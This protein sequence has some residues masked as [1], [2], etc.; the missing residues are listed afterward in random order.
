MPIQQIA[1]ERFSLISPGSFEQVVAALDAVL[2]HPEMHE[3]GASMAATES[4]QQLEHV[5]HAATGRSGFLEFARFD[6]GQVLSKEQGA[7]APK[8]L[9]IVL[10]N[11]LVMKQ[12]VEHVPDAASY[13]PVTVLIDERADGVHLSYDRMASYLAPYGNLAALE[14]ARE[15]DTKIEVLLTRVAS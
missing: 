13:A 2:G 6:L 14:V 12:M 4:W 11:P 15:L 7:K 9:R 10:G 8:I 3:F 5:V 1:V